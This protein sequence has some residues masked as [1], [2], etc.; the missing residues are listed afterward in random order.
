MNENYVTSY[1]DINE[2][3]NNKKIIR[4]VLK[5]MFAGLKFVC[6]RLLA[7]IGI[8]ITL[9]LMGIIAILIKLDSKG[10]VL[11]RQ[12]RTG[13]N[14]K[15]FYI[16]KFRTMV[17]NNDVHDFNVTDKHTRVGKILRKTSLDELP[18]LYSIVTGKMSFIGPRPW[19]PDYYENMSEVQRHRY[20]VRPGLTGLA[21]AKGRNSIKILDKINY[22]L[23]Y[24][25]NYSLKQD[26][27]IIFLTIKM[28]FSGDGA[29]AGK[30]TIQTE[31]EELKR[32]QNGDVIND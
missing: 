14:G 4:R 21:Q 3:I 20:D 1:L 25:K 16:C 11:F 28:V 18:Q 32:Y 12:K 30:T 9:P 5:I 13:R 23:E 2:C 7:F 19:I 10:P 26:I 27:K 29:D 31:L 24:I 8:V 6:D 17:S 22:D 15:N